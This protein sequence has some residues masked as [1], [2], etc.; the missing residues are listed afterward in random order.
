MQEIKLET[1]ADFKGTLSGER[2]PEH[3]SVYSQALWWSGKGNW[4]RA[5][6]L[7]QDVNDSSAALI[8][9]YLHRLE[10]DLSNA[11]YWYAKAN[12][13]MPG[14]DTGKEWEKLVVQFLSFPK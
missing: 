14:F 1:L 2:P 11:K 4:D 6:D 8:H 5:H 12:A 3:L 13:R 7:I 10:G 9:A